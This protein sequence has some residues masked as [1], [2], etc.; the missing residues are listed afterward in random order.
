MITEGDWK[1]NDEKHIWHQSKIEETPSIFMK[2][3]PPDE[4][5]KN[6]EVFEPELVTTE[7]PLN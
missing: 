4:F 3:L 2:L 7:K 6:I 1:S 5:A